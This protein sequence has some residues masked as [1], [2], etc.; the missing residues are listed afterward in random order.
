MTAPTFSQP[1]AGWASPTLTGLAAE[2]AAH[3]T[4]VIKSANNNAPRSRQRSIGPSEIGTPCVRR[5]A[6]K[7]LDWDPK[8]NSDTDPWAAIVGTAVHAWLEHTFGAANYA[9]PDGRPR[10][11][12]ERRVA[13]DAK[14][15]GSSD[16]LDRYFR[17]VIDWKVPGAT[18]MTEYR[19]KQDPGLTYRV[20]AHTYGLGYANAGEDIEHVAIVFLP[21]S[22]RLD[23]IWV[24]TEPFQPILAQAALQRR[25]NVL[26][27]VAALDPEANP[28]NWAL[29]PTADAYCTY[30]PWFLPKSTDLSRGCPGANQ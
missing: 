9:L 19:K 20:Q 22:G 4:H 1:T 30:C 13:A 2:I 15:V 21:R 6:Y 26:Q 17:C 8:P 25:D 27:T 3:V 14:L 29:F 10:Y 24:W 28:A 5:L 16:L 12:L 23:G 7:L 11:V 18:A